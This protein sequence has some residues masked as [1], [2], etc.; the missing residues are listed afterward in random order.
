MADSIAK[1][2]EDIFINHVGELLGTPPDDDHPLVTALSYEPGEIERIKLPMVTMF[3]LLPQGKD[4]ETGGGQEVDHSWAIYLYVA[5]VDWEKAQEQM[6]DISWM[7]VT[8]Y[9]QHYADYTNAGIG[10]YERTLKR[11]NPP[12]PND[13]AAWLRGSWEL[14]V[15]ANEL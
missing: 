11:Q 1:Q 5:L 7:L 8:N 4:V 2:I 14:S 13:G 6:R 10:L 3:Y 12:L 9:R 15:T